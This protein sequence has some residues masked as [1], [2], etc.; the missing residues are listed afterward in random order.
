MRGDGKR[1]EPAKPGGLGLE[2]TKSTNLK[3]TQGPRPCS[4]AHSTQS[5]CLRFP[6]PVNGKLPG[7]RACLSTLDRA[8]VPFSA[9]F[10]GEV[11]GCPSPTRCPTQAA[12]GNRSEGYVHEVHHAAARLQAEALGTQV[13][14]CKKTS[15]NTSTPQ[16]SAAPRRGPQGDG[17][18]ASTIPG[19]WHGKSS[20]VGASGHFYR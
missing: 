13:L 15:S 18:Q 20:R 9:L 12:S 14:V 4:I 5:L 2:N 16:A 17:D 11:T 3:V 7:K 1:Q 19:A 6:F 8:F 10:L